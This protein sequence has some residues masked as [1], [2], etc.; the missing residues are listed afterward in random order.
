MSQ[1]FGD[2]NHSCKIDFSA[3]LWATDSIHDIFHAAGLFILRDVDFVAETENELLLVEYKNANLPQASH[4]EAFRPM[5]DKRINNVA[6]K[7]FN[8]LQ[9]LQAM[10]RGLAKKKHYV[11]ILECSNGDIVLRKHVRELL[12]ARLPFAL[13]KQVAMPETMIDSIEVLSI[14]EWNERYGLFPLQLVDGNGA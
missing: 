11:Y 7:Y 1:I 4:P 5:E 12:A 14:D 6:L 10:H 8:S 3:A 9:L 2:E 13:Q